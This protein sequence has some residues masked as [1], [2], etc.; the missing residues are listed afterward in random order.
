LQCFMWTVV[1]LNYQKIMH[2]IKMQYS[3]L[4][5]NSSS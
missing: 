5:I 2:F 1:F 3:M 4:Y